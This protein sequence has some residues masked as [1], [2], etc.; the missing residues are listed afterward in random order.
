MSGLRIET[1]RAFASLFSL[2]CLLFSFLVLNFNY[3]CVFIV[4]TLN[5]GESCVFIGPS[6]V[7]YFYELTTPVNNRARKPVEYTL[8]RI[9]LPL[10]HSVY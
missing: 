5:N 4:V 3:S 9:V 6:K 8:H 2:A 1:L 10:Y 7:L